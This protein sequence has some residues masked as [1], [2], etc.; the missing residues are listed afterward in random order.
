MKSITVESRV[1]PDG[2]L[3]LELPVGIPNS[4]VVVIVVPLAPEKKSPEDLG[5]PPGLL[6]TFAGSIPDFPD[7]APQGGY[8]VRDELE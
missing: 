4:E 2:I 1:G 8:E 5:W 7:R 3:K 6:D